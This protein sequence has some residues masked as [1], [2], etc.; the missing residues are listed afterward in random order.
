MTELILS[1]LI[2]DGPRKGLVCPREEVEPLL[3]AE[4]LL[5]AHL[6]AD[7]PDADSFLD[8]HLPYVD[9]MLHEALVADD[10][11]P[12]CVAVGGGALIM[13]RGVN[14][15]AGALP[16]D[17]ISIRLWIDA[18]RVVTLRKRNLKAVEDL[19]ANIRSGQGPTTP[20][21]FIAD[22]ARLLTERMEPLLDTLEDTVAAQEQNVLDA[23]GPELRREIAAT[24]RQM[25]IL[26]RYIAP[27]RDAMRA[28][29]ELNVDWLMPDDHHDLQETADRV[30]RHVE[31][32]DM[33][34]ERAQVIRDELANILSDRMNRNLYTLAVLSAVFLPLGFITGL[35]GVNVGGIPGATASWAFAA[36]C[37]GLA[38]IGGAILLMLWRRGWM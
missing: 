17:M 12:R 29:K 15:Q 22:F 37:G 26:R 36:L 4:T 11:R 31:D 27:Q 33:L 3:D 10:T 38:M 16:E 30:M 21:A 34:R 14:L 25:I 9:D 1:S 20:G 18:R 24:R 19:Q 35:L 28:L 7:H 5:W 23:P 13:L 32:L 8:R 6:D 2:L